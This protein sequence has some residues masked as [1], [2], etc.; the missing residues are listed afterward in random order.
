MCTGLASTQ[1]NI[2]KYWLELVN[3]SLKVEAKPCKNVFSVL[4]LSSQGKLETGLL[5][6]WGDECDDYLPWASPLN[7][8]EVNVSSLLLS[9]FKIY[10]K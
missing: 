6:V 10:F 4:L 9:N 3:I 1:S 5:E 7:A 2:H 8:G